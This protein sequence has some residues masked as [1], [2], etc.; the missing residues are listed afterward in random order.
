[1]LCLTVKQPWAWAII[2]GPKRIENRTWLTNHRGPLLIHAGVSRS[3]FDTE[4]RLDWRQRYGIEYPSGLMF[5]TILG[6]VDL[7]DCRRVE[8]VAADPWAEGPFCWMLD[9]PR[10]LTEPFPLRGMPGLFDVDLNAH[11]SLIV[12]EVG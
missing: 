6:V 8:T 7:I 5:G 12:P 4:T 2:S 11:P 9:K 1:M 10:A 3:C